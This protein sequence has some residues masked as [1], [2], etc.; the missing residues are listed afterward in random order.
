LKLDS[1]NGGVNLGDSIQVMKSRGYLQTGQITCHD[2]QGEEISCDGSGQDAE[3]RR[4]IPWP[5]PR[6]ERQRETVLDCL[7]GLFWM[8]D[9]NIAEFPMTWQEAL[10]YISGMNDR[11]A[12]DYDD[13]RLPN[14]REL[15]S[16]ISHQTKKPA[17]PEGHPFRNV[18]PGWY[19]TSTTAAIN[20]AYAWYVHMEGARMFYGSKK[21]SYLLWPV[22][23]KGYGILPITGQTKCY[24][25]DGHL[26]RCAG[27]AQ[28]AEFRFG[29]AWPEKRFEVYSDFAV[30]YLTGLCWLRTANLT[31]EPV[32]WDDAFEAIRRLNSKPDGILSWRL[33]NINELES[34]VDSST[35]SPALPAGHPF[36][37][38][39]EAYWSSTTSMFE[40]DWAWAL[41]LTKGA[42]GVGQKWGAHFHVWAVCDG[43]DIKKL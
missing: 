37:E 32:T 9:A 34:I 1:S 38:V 7:T 17:L 39:Q 20:S 22:R 24:D 5:D 23:G 12:F 6:F 14:R 15:R 25:S 35:H 8:R 16:L 43:Y 29:L 26:V 19:W 4:G 11:K 42:V 18:F 21:Q 41:Y 13:W 28:D 36:K 10:D 2:T 40:P 33:P 3:F 27:T 30:D 31:N